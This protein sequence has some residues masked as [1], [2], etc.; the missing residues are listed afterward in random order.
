MRLLKMGVEKFIIA[1]V[2]FF[3]FLIPD[4]K[5]TF[6]FLVKLDYCIKSLFV[7]AD[8]LAATFRG[9]ASIVVRSRRYT[10]LSLNEML[11]FR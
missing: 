2:F 6:F 3:S 7:I 1:L 4:E 5:Q 8:F 9:L 10:T 11:L